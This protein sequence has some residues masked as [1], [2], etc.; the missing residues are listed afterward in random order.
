MDKNLVAKELVK[1][2]KTLMAGG[3]GRFS[4]DLADSIQ[5]QV[6]KQRGKKGMEIMKI[7]KHDVGLVAMMEEERMSDRDLMEIIKESMFMFG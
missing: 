1:L 6:V 5:G 3:W 4:E 2:A 7:I